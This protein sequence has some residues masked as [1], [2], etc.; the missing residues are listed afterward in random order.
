LII[1]LFGPPGGGK[2]TQAAFIAARLAIPGIS[3]GELFRAQLKAGTR[4]GKLTCSILS[5][6]GFVSDD[7]VNDLVAEHTSSSNCSSGF[8]LDGYPR[9]LPQARFLDKTLTQRDLG[10]AV[11]VHLDVPSSVI[12]GRTTA[13]RQCPAC[14]R[15]YSR[16]FQ[17]PKVD[18]VCDHDRTPLISREDDRE[19]VVLE[20]LKVY[21]ELT[22]PVIAHY[23]ALPSYF[24]VDGTCGP[25]EV[26][27]QIERVLDAFPAPA[28]S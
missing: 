11:A 27:G 12:I 24:K 8:L 26:S 7:I 22:A 14:L 6:G 9:T 13:R 19:S 5:K 21:S 28:Q 3:T 23:A 17:P 15:T 16:L 20:R 2:S 25:A 10:P 4:L 1:V 18:G